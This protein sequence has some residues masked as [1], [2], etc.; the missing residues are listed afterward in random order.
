[1]FGAST[2]PFLWNKIPKSRSWLDAALRRDLVEHI[3]S[4]KAAREQTVEERVHFRLAHSFAIPA[5][6]T[7]RG[8]SSEVRAQH[9][10]AV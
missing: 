10:H 1:M 4:G 5:A 6:H 8:A 2:S 7:L 9:R 3:L